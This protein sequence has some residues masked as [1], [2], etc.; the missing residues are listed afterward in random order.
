MHGI[1]D[2]PVVCTVALPCGKLSIAA[3]A[4]TYETR[5]MSP[6]ITTPQFPDE[7][8]SVAYIDTNVG[9]IFLN[10]P[11]ALNSL[12]E[13]M[14]KE[15]RDDLRKW[16]QHSLHAIIIRSSRS[17][18]FCAGGDVKAIRELSLQ[19]HDDSVESFF[20][21]EYVMNSAIAEYDTP[22]VSLIDGVCMGG[23][24]GISIHGRF[25]VVSER[26]KL[27]M[28]ETAIG[29]FP[30]VGASYFLPRLPGEVGMYLGLTGITMDYR[31]ALYCGLATN[32]V[33]STHIDELP[34]QIAGSPR[35]PIASIL[36]EHDRPKFSEPGHLESHRQQIDRCFAAPTYDGVLQRLSDNGTEWSNSV[37]ADLEKRSP[38]SLRITFALL[39]RGAERTLDACLATELRLAKAVTTSHDFIEG[40]RSLLVDK[41]KNP[42]WQETPS[43]DTHRLLDLIMEDPNEPTQ[44][45]TEH[46]SFNAS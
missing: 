37:L 34:K 33:P 21:N 1:V 27:A 35:T 38:Q 42:R 9:N 43:S 19:G 36:A 45:T 22:V 17:K 16:E 6:S 14:V 30:D 15:I 13:S 29:F 4:G 20:S 5:C 25:R 26:A 24:M 10:R 44:S 8:S 28:P 2:I 40:V 46:S 41:D 12:D 23:G 3:K 32:F 39:R 7:D 18:I 11:K 31:D